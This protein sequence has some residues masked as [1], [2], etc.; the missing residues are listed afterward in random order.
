MVEDNRKLKVA[1]LGQK[2]IPSRKGGVE[3][4][5][6]ELSERMVKSGI[7]VTCYN[8]R[9]KGEERPKEYNGI[10][11]KY[12]W[13]IDKKG[14]AALTSSFFATIMVLFSRNNVV[15]YHAEGP[16]A[17]LWIIK[18]FSKKK[19]IATIHGLDWQRAKWGG[20]A[21][22]W[23]KFGEKVAA[24]HADEIIVLSKNAQKYFKEQYN[25]E[26]QFIPNGI[27]KPKILSAKEITK[28]YGLK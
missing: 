25:R 21:S 9:E 5:V 28:K 26:T 7:E 16:C 23:I 27:S 3:V 24:K 14:L 22:K 18:F 4:V 17:W 8:R 1:M 10:K 2:T 6:K 11:L 15:H 19:I 20:F 13:T 12:A